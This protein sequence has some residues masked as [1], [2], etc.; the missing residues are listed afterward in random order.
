[1]EIKA[2]SHPNERRGIDRFLLG[3]SSEF[4]ATVVCDNQT[5]NC[6]LIDF[7]F[8]GARIKLV[9]DLEKMRPTNIQSLSIFYGKKVIGE[10]VEPNVV[11][12]NHDGTLSL[13]FYSSEQTRGQRQKNRLNIKDKFL[14]VVMGRDPI[15]IGA[16]AHFN[17]LNFTSEGFQLDTSL[18][19]KHLLVGME[20]N[21]ATLLLPGVDVAQVSFKIMNM[22][23]SS[24]RIRLGCKF[25]KP[26]TSLVEKLARFGLFATLPPNQSGIMDKF[27]AVKNAIG[28]IRK[29]RS[30]VRIELV[31]TPADYAKVLQVRFKSYKEANKLDEN[32]T[33]E[34]MADE[35]D[36]RSILLAAKIDSAIV[37]T[38]RLVA[39]EETGQTF[40]FESYLDFEKL[41]LNLERP[42]YFE[43]SRLAVDPDFQGTDV[44]ISIFKEISKNAV[45]NARSLLCIAAKSLRQ[46]YERIGFRTISKEMPHKVLKNETMA[47]MHANTNEFIQGKNVAAITYDMIVYDVLSNMHFAGIVSKPKRTLQKMIR[48]QFELLILKTMKA[49]KKYKKAR[50]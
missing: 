37:A 30:A 48:K 43:V 47:I 1:M 24:G 12:D 33:V 9:G 41:K 44:L 11:R 23:R 17:M 42:S 46:N 2:K 26:D 35:F 21:D 25:I 32:A 40:P 15:K 18:S 7:H 19:N 27:E 45:V 20:I 31:S 29:L 36:Q 39:A 16:I 34:D 14:P 10:Y 22:R 8:E 50:N 28:P 6:Q 13:Q 38:V 49:S 5:Y 4:S 3:I